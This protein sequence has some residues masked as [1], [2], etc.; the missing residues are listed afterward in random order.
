MTENVPRVLRAKQFELV[1]DRGFVRAMLY[2]G[3]EDT[4]ALEFFEDGQTPRVS[5]GVQ[6][7]GTAVLSLRDNDGNIR[8][9][10]ATEWQGE[11]TVFTLRDAPDKIRAQIVL[12]QNG[13]VG[14]SLSD[15]S[16]KKSISLET[17]ADGTSY[18]A[19]YDENGNPVSGL[20]G[21]GLDSEQE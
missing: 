12:D 20:V 21:Q 9:R 16:G 7:N 5:V 4:A 18:I 15:Q 14:V 8:A 13:G 6:Q 2:S 17:H 10:L 11:P 3:P 1:D 19:L